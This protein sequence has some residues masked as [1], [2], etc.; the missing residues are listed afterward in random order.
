[1][2]NVPAVN[3]LLSEYMNLERPI[4]YGALKEIEQRVGH[5]KFPLVPINYYSSPSTMVCKNRGL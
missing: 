2:A 1:M 3:S 5:D 4:M